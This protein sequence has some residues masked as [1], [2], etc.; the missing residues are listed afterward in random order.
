VESSK[1]R[2][3]HRRAGAVRA[4]ESAFSRARTDLVALTV[5]ILDDKG[6]PA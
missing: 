2:S 1:G 4:A 5:T 6:A 3:S